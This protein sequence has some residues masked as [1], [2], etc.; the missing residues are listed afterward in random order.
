MQVVASFYRASAASMFAFGEL[1]SHGISERQGIDAL[2]LPREVQLLLCFYSRVL[3]RTKQA[4][5][6]SKRTPA[7]ELSVLDCELDRLG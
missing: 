6:G 7:L 5:L 2:S 4:T 3:T 1:A